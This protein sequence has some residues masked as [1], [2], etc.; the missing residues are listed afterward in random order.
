MEAA[1][2]A[3]SPN[4]ENQSSDVCSRAAVDSGRKAL[5]RPAWKKGGVEEVDEKPRSPEKPA[6][7]RVWTEATGIPEIRRCPGLQETRLYEEG[8]QPR[9]W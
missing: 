5:V 7:R 8:D 6:S 1:N 2:S 4:Q 3:E 9:K